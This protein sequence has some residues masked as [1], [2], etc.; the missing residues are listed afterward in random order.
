MARSQVAL[1][2][3]TCAFCGAKVREDRVRCLRCG[4]P[5]VA[6]ATAAAQYSARLMKLLAGAGVLAAVALAGVVA[7][8]PSPQT[9]R[10][11]PSLTSAAEAAPVRPPVEPRASEAAP[12]FLR[13]TSAFE[14]ALAGQGAYQRGDVSGALEHYRQAVQLEPNNPELLNN[15]G[16]V[17]VRAGRAREATDYFDRAIGLAPGVWA[18]HFNRGRAFAVL[19]QWGQALASYR[20]AQQLFPDDYV[21][22]FNLAQ[23]L[24][25]SGDLPAAIQA[26]ERAIQLAPGQAD[27]HLSHGLALEAA[28]RPAEAVAAYRRFLDLASDSPEADRVKG[29]IAELTGTGPPS[30]P[31]AQP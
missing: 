26:Y 1:D 30:A 21:T 11:M 17:L 24:R 16:Q 23:A 18:Y 2:A 27:F 6:A 4:K 25:G 15:L 10:L 19:E 31:G 12:A 29:R 5:L 8:R 14:G 3:V 28:S 13:P 20:E 7:L 22:Q 9:A